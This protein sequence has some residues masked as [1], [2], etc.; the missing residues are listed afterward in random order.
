MSTF[1]GKENKQGKYTLCRLLIAAGLTI[2]SLPK[3][4]EVLLILVEKCI[5]YIFTGIL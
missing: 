3:L 5:D 4:A 1:D 2:E